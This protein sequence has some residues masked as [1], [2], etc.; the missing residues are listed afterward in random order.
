MMGRS[1]LYYRRSILFFYVILLLP[2]IIKHNWIRISNVVRY[3]HF[4]WRLADISSNGTFQSFVI[5]TQLVAD[6]F[7][8]PG[9]AYITNNVAT[10]NK[11]TLAFLLHLTHPRLVAPSAAKQSA[12]V[13]S[14]T[15]P[16]A[17]SS[18]GSQD[19]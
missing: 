14:L 7:L 6:V 4:V 11:L 16:I 10:P 5:C 13:H 8:L 2:Q 12:S 18:P 19:I 17:D 9:S 3:M 15:G 1:S